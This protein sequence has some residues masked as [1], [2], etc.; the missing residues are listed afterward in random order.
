MSVGHGALINDRP[1]AW[2]VRFVER[3][4]LRGDNIMLTRE[5]CYMHGA[6]SIVNVASV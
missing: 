5:V 2:S 4:F 3:H 1:R 6:P